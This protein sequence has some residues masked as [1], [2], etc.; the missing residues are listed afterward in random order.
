MAIQLD[1]QNGRFYLR[2]KNTMYVLGLAEGKHLVHLY[3]GKHRRD[4][5]F[6]A[7][8]RA[9]HFC[10]Y[11]ADRTTK[12]YLPN[13]AD[14][15]FPFF[16]SGDFRACAL[17]LR[18]LTTGGD[19]TLFL[20]RSAKKRK[21]RVELPGLP[22]AEEDEKTETLELTMEDP[23]TGCQLLLYYTIFPESDV[24]SRY[25]VLKNKSKDP[26]R[27]EKCMSLA[28][29]IP[30]D[31][32]DM[33]SFQGEYGFER[34]YQRAPLIHGGQRI[35]SRR[36]AS[37]HDYNPFFMLAA[38]K[39]TEERGEAYGFNL[40]FSGSFLDEVEV[41]GIKTTRVLVGLGEECFSYL[42]EPGEEFCSPEAIMTYTTHGIGQISRNMHRFVRSH[43]LPPDKFPR[44][45]VVLNS[46]EA[47]W[48][49][50]DEG[51]MVDFAK[52]AKACG[53][54]M[55]VM[56]DGWFGARINDH[57]GLGDWYENRDKFANGLKS[58][59]ERVKAEGVKFGIWIEPEMV[60]PDSDLFRAHPDW[61]L[62]TPG[63]EPLQARHQLVL[64][65]ANPEVID[66]LKESFAKVF[67]GVDIDYFKWD[68]NRHMTQVY[69]PALP[70]K[71][72]GEA[73][74]RYM[75]GVYRL[76]AWF[77]EHFPNAMIENCSGGGGRYDL[78]MMK[79]STQI[80]TSDETMP[81]KR[82]FIQ[83]GST[84][85]YPT[86]TMSCHVAK[87]DLCRDPRWLNFDFR[88]ALN[89]PLGYEM[90]I[91]QA[92]EDMKEAMTKQI[93]EYRRYE[94]LI[95]KGDFYRLLNPFTD[96]GRYAFYF[97]NEEN[98]QILLTY[99]QNR[100][101]PKQRPVKLKI[102]RADPN[103][104]YTDTLSGVTY[105]GADLRR[106]IELDSDAEDFCATTFHF[107]KV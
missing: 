54:D 7:P 57:A 2:T 69:S 36:G 101:D 21:G 70:P 51:L 38:P 49:K 80:W 95:L 18:N 66:Y 75:L 40:V 55:L 26:M 68:M 92:S 96:E 53:M 35:F 74:Y 71:R 107:C 39:T 50:I 45:P 41:C 3:Y 52:E 86:S 87:L 13:T 47:F 99:L 23:A 44:R 24:I 76:F 11:F 91:L 29:D 19:A 67:D 106:G 15:E 97:V 30:R 8:T 85:G 46:W 100:G 65:M 4:L 98:S 73:A 72:Q 90:N 62:K 103:A 12:S 10:P 59:V 14:A 60:N 82:V 5:D 16:G 104:R 81:D 27:I 64:D 37:S 17:R 58:F 43:I 84:F 28:L 20:Y 88:V 83:C 32:L 22:Y 34:V 33:I 89:G 93:E 105:E 25:F 61:I 1:R 6:S 77:N 42:L 9:P 31:G 63:Y 48:F 79:Y 102:S 94:P 78:G 56:D